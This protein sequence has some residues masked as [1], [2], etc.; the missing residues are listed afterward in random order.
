MDMIFF[1]IMMIFGVLPCAILG[2]LIKYR[3]SYSLIAG[4]DEKGVNNP[5]LLGDRIGNILFMTSI[6]LLFLYLDIEYNSDVSAFGWGI[7]ILLLIAPVMLAFRA[8]RLDGES[9][10]LTPKNNDQDGSEER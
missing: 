4:Y 8:A 3:G 7:V 6:L 2:Y 5:K 9:H 1:A 10:V